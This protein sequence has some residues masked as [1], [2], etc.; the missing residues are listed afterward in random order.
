MRAVE[1]VFLL[2]NNFKRYIARGVELGY[3]DE[4][5]SSFDVMQIPI[6]VPETAFVEIPKLVCQHDQDEEWRISSW[7]VG[8]ADGDFRTLRFDE[9]RLFD[10]V[11]YSKMFTPTFFYIKIHLPDRREA[12]HVPV[13]YFETALKRFYR[14]IA[15]I[16]GE[17]N[18]AFR[19][20][21][22]VPNV[23]DVV[24]DNLPLSFRTFEHMLK[25]PVLCN[26]TCQFRSTSAITTWLPASLVIDQPRRS[27]RKR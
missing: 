5:T 12:S 19:A 20:T 10:Y 26:K 14:L 16:V 23:V 27:K 3:Y 25:L 24:Y 17:T 8:C 2:R 7:Y 1:T 9:F 18:L 22:D 6:D 11:E 21:R 15:E 13:E 4:Y